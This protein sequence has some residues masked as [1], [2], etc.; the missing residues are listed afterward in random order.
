M[1]KIRKILCLIDPTSSQQPAMNKA[2]WLA[3][4]IG[5]E[6]ELFVCLYG[7]THV[8][9]QQIDSI[10]LQEVR[11]QIS[12]PIRQ[13]L[14]EY[15]LT[16]RQ[17]NLQVTVS[18]DFDRPLYEGIVR[19]AQACDADVVFKDT[20]HHTA[21]NRALMTNTDWN[22]IRQCPIPLWLVRSTTVPQLGVI[23]AAIDPM[24]HHDK[25]AALDDRILLMGQSLAKSTG[26]ELHAFHSYNPALALADANANA[27]LPVS[28]PYDEIKKDMRAKHGARFSEIVDFHEIANNR[29][30]LLSGQT[31][32]ELPILADKLGADLVIMGAVARSRW[33]HLFIGATAE[34][35]LEDL[36][37][38]LLIIKPDLFR[39]SVDN[40]ESK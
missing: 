30:H 37:C 6:I 21:I 36:P 40:R 5:A 33:Q 29:R 25:P 39:T 11:K 14:E 23:V 38:D 20:H 12:E 34:R 22:L 9:D 19:H 4:A 3:S 31:S 7:E 10:G 24:H 13:R 2:A 16:L 17:R 18:L 15:A 26:A 28:L 8:G 1:K 32:E 27:Y 35:I